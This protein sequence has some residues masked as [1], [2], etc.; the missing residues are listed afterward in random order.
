[1]LPVS[2]DENRKVGEASLLGLAGFCVIVAAGATVSIVHSTTVA[3]P[4]LPRGS[5]ARTP[6]VCSPSV[7][8]G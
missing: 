5:V 2:F 4:V 8:L 6:K 1:M 3:S 7:R